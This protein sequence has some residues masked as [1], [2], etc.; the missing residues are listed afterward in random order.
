MQIN[1]YV[2]GE[3]TKNFAGRVIENEA[4]KEAVAEAARR[5]EKA[6]KKA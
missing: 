2:N 6:E 1:R 3:K 5:A 4:V